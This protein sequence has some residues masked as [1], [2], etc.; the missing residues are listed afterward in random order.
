MGNYE[1]PV[2]L[3]DRPGTREA[4]SLAQPQH[5]LEAFDGPPRRPE[6]LEPP[7]LGMFFFTRKWSLSIPC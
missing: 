7:I 4:E 6:A 1:H 3:A 2:L 5:S